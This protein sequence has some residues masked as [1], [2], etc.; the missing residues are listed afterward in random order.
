M[1]TAVVGS[2]DLE[3]DGTVAYLLLNT[4]MELDAGEILLRRPLHVPPR[5]F[6]VLVGSLAIPLG[7]E[8]S[9]WTPEP[10]GRAEVFVRDVDMVKEADQVVAFFPE[11]AE[12]T[13][14][15]GHVVEKALDQKKP[16]RAYAVV[17]GELILV[18]ADNEVS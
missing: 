13:G 1:K 6:E 2:R 10:G 11:G 18:G 15:T 8:V 3:L 5:A 16:V 14:G 4:L 7:F 12:M 9:W 17:D